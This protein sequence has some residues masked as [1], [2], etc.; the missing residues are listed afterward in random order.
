MPAPVLART[1]S[2]VILRDPQPATG[3]RTVGAPKGYGVT[4]RFVDVE[5][6]LPQP[7]RDVL[8]VKVVGLHDM[9][10]PAKLV[11]VN[12]NR[13]AL[14]LRCGK[15]ETDSGAYMGLDELRSIPITPDKVRDGEFAET[16]RVRLSGQGRVD[17]G[18]FI[19]ELPRLPRRPPSSLPRPPW[20]GRAYL[21]NLMQA[22]PR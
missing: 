15:D 9:D 11:L 10:R 2:L 18:A 12:Y 21:S 4:L 13:N 7:G 16:C 3:L 6:Q 17:I 1:P 19:S 8:G 14:T 5:W 20:I 22:R